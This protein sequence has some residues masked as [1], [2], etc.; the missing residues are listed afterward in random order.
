MDKKTSSTREQILQ[1]LKKHKSLTVAHLASS[2]GITEMA[3]RRHLSTLERDQMVETKI[4]RQAMGRPSTLYSLSKEGEEVFP[5]NYAALTL[6]FLKDIEKLNGKQMIDDLFELRRQR[7][8]EEL[9]VRFKGKSFDERIQELAN[10]QTKNG[11]MVEWEKTD[12]GII[13]FK[14]YNCPISQI[15]EEFPVACACEQSLFQ[16]LLETEEIECETCMAINETPHCYYKIK[17]PV[18]EE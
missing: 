18:N 8:K 12:D 13:H 14:E 4:V 3:V 15:A 16:D 11:Y 5:R 10:L 9:E 7:M 17:P 2:L 6:G 1:L